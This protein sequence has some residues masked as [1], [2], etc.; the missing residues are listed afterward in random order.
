MIKVKNLERTISE[1]L[2]KIAK[3]FAD[4]FTMGSIDLVRGGFNHY[5]D[6][7]VENPAELKVSEIPFNKFNCVYF[8]MD[9]DY[10][11]YVG[12]TSHLSAR[13]STHVNDGKEFDSVSWVC[14]DPGDLLLIE[15]FNIAHYNPSLNIETAGMRELVL[16]VAR[17][18]S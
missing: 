17:K 11:A 15:A 9:G 10:V 16:M 6:K 4:E 13:I 14:V 18:V 8:L 2:N 12:Q 5:L 1:N 7:I 3:I